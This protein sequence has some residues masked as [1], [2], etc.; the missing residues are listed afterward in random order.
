MGREPVRV[1]RGDGEERIP[2]Y[3]SIIM[4]PSSHGE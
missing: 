3:E 1:R 2:V 4:K